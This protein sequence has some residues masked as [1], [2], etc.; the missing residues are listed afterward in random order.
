MQLMAIPAK[1]P[2]QDAQAG[3]TVAARAQSNQARPFL[4]GH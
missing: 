3:N 1:Q 2:A 4:K